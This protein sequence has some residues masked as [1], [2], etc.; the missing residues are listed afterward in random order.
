MMGGWD[1]VG[2]EMK[3]LYILRHAKSSWDDESLDDFDRSL[4][5]RGLTAAP[6]MGE[7]LAAYGAVPDLILCSPAKRSVETLE[8]LVQA[9]F[10]AKNHKYSEG[11]YLAGAKDLL[12][13]I[14]SLDET[15]MSVM[16]IGH[17][18]GLQNLIVTLCNH[19]EPTNEQGL[20]LLDIANK[21]PTAGFA[22]L[23]FDVSRWSDIAPLSGKLYVAVSPKLLAQ[24]GA[25]LAHDHPDR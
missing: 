13:M 10:E 19:E 16:I 4:N 24:K 21:F 25:L 5:G 9:G 14:K 2:A 8:L 1:V 11:L 22:H 3:N 15:I 20:R 6:L 7:W 18:P 17:N 12:K 23:M